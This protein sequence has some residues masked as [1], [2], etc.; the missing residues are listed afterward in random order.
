MSAIKGV[1][2]DLD[3]TLIDSAPV[4]GEI[5]NEMRAESDL[6]SLPLGD[7]RAWISLGAT[8]L[9]ARAMGGLPDE[10]ALLEEFRRR[11]R[12]RPTPENAVFSGAVSA[13]G[14]LA[15]HGIKLGVCSNKPEALCKKVLEET[16][17]G[18]F[19]DI[20]VGGDTTPKRKP[21]REPIEFALAGL[22]VG[23]D[24]VVLVGDSTVDQ[25]A[26]RAAGVPF[27][28]FSG[29]YDDGV[30]VGSVARVISDLTEIPSVVIGG[31]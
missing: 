28:F 22:A 24:A 26:S 10:I 23:A 29:G 31:S 6:A 21:S 25:E 20:V 13:I 11:Y 16:R 17:L 19:F 30:D 7:Y 5:L 18:G 15:L 9:I 2:F 27:I 12:K 4:I 14:A 8:E 1:L 3:G